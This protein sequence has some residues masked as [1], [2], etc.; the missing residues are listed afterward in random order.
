MRVRAVLLAAALVLTPLSARAA[1]LVVWW[2]EGF[3]PEED[4]AVRETVAAF[5]GKT[6]KRVEL[7]RPAQ[8]EVSD[9]V[10]AALEAGQPPDFLYGTYVT[11]IRIFQWAYEDRLVDLTAALGPLRG[12]FDAEILDLSMLPNGRTGERGLYGLPMACG[13]NHVHVWRSLL[14]RAGFTLADIPKDW[15]AFWSF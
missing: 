1:D 12:L 5:E 4:A 2:E 10:Q 13:S 15:E 6:G 11:A 7:V 9:K 8:D 14:E 3:H